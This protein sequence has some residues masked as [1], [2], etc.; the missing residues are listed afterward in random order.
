MATC[1]ESIRILSLNK[2]EFAGAR[3]VA[4]DYFRG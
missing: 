3:K 4:P 2:L 1:D